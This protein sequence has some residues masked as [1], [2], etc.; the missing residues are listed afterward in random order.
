[1]CV[2]GTVTVGFGEQAHCSARQM[3]RKSTVAVAKLHEAFVLHPL[4]YSNF[5]PSDF[6][7][8][9][10][11]K[12]WLSGCQFSCSEGTITAGGLELRS[13]RLHV[14]KK[15]YAVAVVSLII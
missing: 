3:F 12:I 13:V 14:S 2:I 6:F 1:M 10:N 15:M 4:Y 5:D 8:F 11:S 7:L 9:V